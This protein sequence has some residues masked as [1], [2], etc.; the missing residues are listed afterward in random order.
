MSTP[1]KD[2]NATP[3]A[4]ETLPQVIPAE[5][6]TMVLMVEAD[7][8]EAGEED[9]SNRT[10]SS[11]AMVLISKFKVNVPKVGAVIDTNSKNTGE[12]FSTLQNT[13]QKML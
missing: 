2:G 3:P 5:V 7:K 11:T 13:K 10:G 6:E 9:I 4:S 1:A 8:E 12:S